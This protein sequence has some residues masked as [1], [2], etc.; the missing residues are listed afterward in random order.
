MPWQ[1]VKLAGVCCINCRCCILLLKYFFPFMNL[2]VHRSGAVRKIWSEYLQRACTYGVDFSSD[3]HEDGGRGGLM[4]AACAL[5][6]V[7]YCRAHPVSGSEDKLLPKCQNHNP[8]PLPPAA[9][10]TSGWGLT[11]WCQQ[12]FEHARLVQMQDFNNPNISDRHACSDRSPSGG[13][14]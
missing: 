5:L 13:S 10:S 2:Y 1:I 14:L 8:L 3:T 7:R 11:H 9:I 12:A 6:E 4:S